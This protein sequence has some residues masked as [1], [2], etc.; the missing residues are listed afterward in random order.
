MKRMVKEYAIADAY[1]FGKNNFP[2]DFP[3][4]V[5]YYKVASQKRHPLSMYMLGICYYNGSGIKASIETAI[6]YWNMAFEYGEVV[7]SSYEL[8]C[9]YYLGEGL[10]CKDP[11]KAFQMW[12]ISSQNGNTGSMVE[13]GNSYY[14]GDGVEQSIDKALEYWCMARRIRQDN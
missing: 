8:G 2:Q 3:K 12:F 1:Y 4:A 10:L 7:H 5:L 11:Y 6:Y 9:S 14:H 13:V